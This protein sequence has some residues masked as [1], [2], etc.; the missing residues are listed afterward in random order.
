[1]GIDGDTHVPPGVEDNVRLAVRR[2]RRPG[3]TDAVLGLRIADPLLL[4]GRVP[5]LKPV[6]RLV[7]QNRQVTAKRRG[8][9]PAP[10]RQQDRAGVF[11]H[12]PKLTFEP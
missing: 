4:P 11:D 8:I 9:I 2:D 1:M 7:P 10:V 6:A 5:H 3:P 12:L